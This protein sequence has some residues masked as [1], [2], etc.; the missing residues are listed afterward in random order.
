MRKIIP[1]DKRLVPLARKLRNNMTLAEI[2]LWQ[3]I[4]NKQIGV[5][6][7]R[8]IPIDRFIVDFYCKDLLL[9]IEVDGVS[10]YH[11][12]QPVKD[13][14]RQIRLESLGVRFLRF[15]DLDV[16]TNIKWVLNEIYY[17]VEELKAIGD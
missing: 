12:D 2:L 9:A 16:K 10:H 3:E 17:T 13:K 14:R 6:F 7:S 8:Q 1:Y 11:D 15:E 5:R 4:K